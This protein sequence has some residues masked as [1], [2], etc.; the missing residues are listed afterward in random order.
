MWLI[1][2]DGSLERKILLH[3]C[4]DYR[5]SHSTGTR[6]NRVE[7]TRKSY[8]STLMGLA[9]DFPVFESGE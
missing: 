9:V 3:H 2:G 8:R 5:T 6:V 4:T 1:S 7:E